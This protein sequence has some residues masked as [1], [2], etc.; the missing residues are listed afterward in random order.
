MKPAGLLIGAVLAAVSGVA[1]AAPDPAARQRM[2][3][4]LA[5][6]SAISDIDIGNCDHEHAAFS[7]AYA[8]LTDSPNAVAMHRVMG[9]YQ[10]KPEPPAQVE[11]NPTADQ[12]LAALDKA[13]ALFERH[14]DYIQKLAAS[15]PPPAS[16]D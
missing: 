4:I 1:T 3:E 10:L 13:K 6:F 5:E 14:G 15:L 8:A 12:C 7:T 2:V 11:A 16:V 9:H